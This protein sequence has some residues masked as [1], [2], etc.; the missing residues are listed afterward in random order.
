MKNHFTEEEYY[1]YYIIEKSLDEF[2]LP[3]AIQSSNKLLI[4]TF[5]LCDR[6]ILIVTVDALSI[7]QIRYIV[8]FISYIGRNDNF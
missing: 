8:S 3:S 6:T 7:A 1:F 5:S 2:L 4:S